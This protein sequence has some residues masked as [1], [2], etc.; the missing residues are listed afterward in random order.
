MKTN[1]LKNYAT[2]SILGNAHYP[3]KD[4]GDYKKKERKCLL[5]DCI[6]M[7]THNGGFCSAE[8]HKKYHNKLK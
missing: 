8:H 2:I 7:T 5:R 6:K 3:Y 1:F 4:W